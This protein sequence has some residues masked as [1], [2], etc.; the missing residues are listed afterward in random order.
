M[1]KSNL[2]QIISNLD[3]QEFKKF[4]KFIDSPYFN[5]NKKL[6]EFYKIL[7]NYYP[8]FDALELSKENIFRKLYKQ[9]K[10]VMGT[11]YYLI[12]EMEKLLE[13]FLS[14]EKINP[15]TLDLT[16][17]KIIG[18][19][20]LYNIFDVKYKDIK[21][22]LNKIYD[23]ENL[24]NFILSNI[25]RHNKIERKISLTKKDVFQ[26]E[27][28]EPVDELVKLFL[29]NMLWSIAL[30]SNFKKHLNEKLN[31][32]FYNEILDYVEK[33]KNYENDL[34]LNLIF[35]QI[36]MINNNEEKYY[37]KLKKLFIDNNKKIKTE[38]AQELMANLNNFCMQKV[39]TG[40]GYR[41]EQFEIQNLYLKYYIEKSNDN[42]PIDAFNQIFMLGMSLDKV[43]WAKAFI[44]K[45]GQRV[46]EKFQSNA[47]N[48][49]Y[50]L[51]DYREKKFGDALRKLS[52][53]KNYSHIY[54][55][56][57]VKLLQLKIYFELN[58]FSEAE[59]AANSFTQFLRNDKLTTSNI[60]KTYIDFLK[61]Y[62]KLLSVQFSID[63]NKINNFKHEIEKKRKFLLAR[64]WFRDRIEEIEQA[65]SKNKKRKAI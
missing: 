10:V 24:N 55:K 23:P 14:I 42:F 37:F 2:I 63:R 39:I 45:Y 65:S 11:M 53:I 49:S 56:P 30:F 1:K 62:K 22:K 54:Y 21:K 35:Y 12:S 26:K 29:K 64:K 44:H 33:N 40:F 13:K 32:P 15:I 16:S 34:E 5:T 52:E 28:M 36:K 51:I 17:L 3:E 6:N 9:D 25:N 31:I 18:D 60:K 43:D 57:S 58:L 41:E 7:V 50:A 4:G 46:E 19:M 38:V 47:L 27:W 61:I 20:R 8:E 48:Y 59:D